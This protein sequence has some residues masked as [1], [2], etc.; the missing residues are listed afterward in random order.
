MNISQRQHHLSKVHSL[1]IAKSTSIQDACTEKAGTV[2]TSQLS[3]TV[4]SAAKDMHVP[5]TCIEGIWRKAT[6]LI[7][8]QN[9]IVPAPDQSEEA[10]MVLSFSG[11]TPHLVTPTK[12]GYSC[13]NNCPNWKSIGF[14]SHT[15]A[16]AQINCKLPQF[17][18]FLKK[19]KKAPNITQLVTSNMPRGRGRKGGIPPRKRKPTQEITA[20]VPMTA[21]SSD[22]NT[23][24]KTSIDNGMDPSQQQLPPY[25][26]G[27]HPMPGSSYSYSHQFP[28]TFNCTPPSSMFSSPGPSN[29]QVG[30][31]NPSNIFSPPGSSNPSGSQPG[32]SSR[33]NPPGPYNPSTMSPPGPYNSSTMFS[34]PGSYNPSSIF[35][36]C[37]P[38]STFNSPG[39]LNPF[40]ICFIKGNISV[41]IGCKNRYSK[42]PR[43]PYDLC[44]KHQEW[45]QF[46]PQGSDV[47]QTKYTNVYYHCK[48]ECVWLRNPY[49]NPSSLQTDEVEEQLLPEHKTFLLAI[50]IQWA[51]MICYW[52]PT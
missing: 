3:V 4:E 42:S 21:G 12:S 2:G 43:A 50:K 30:S 52:L 8:D 14:C 46:I 25:F 22:T 32:P 5:M 23:L 31:Y 17:V 28:S 16:V 39:H 35:N 29:S 51:Q 41:C 18:T 27:H 34:Q 33:F 38:S 13:D 11:K 7:C 44:I 49:F 9:A 48:P 24:P 47:P 36:P 26:P 37:Q 10:K 20:R 15:V 45:R 1:A 6:K 19:K 40:K